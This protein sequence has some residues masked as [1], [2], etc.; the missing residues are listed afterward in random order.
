MAPP[1]EVSPYQL[2][3][4]LMAL[5]DDVTQL[6]ARTGSGRRFRP[7][8]GYPSEGLEAPSDPDQEWIRQEIAQ[9]RRRVE[10]LE[11]WLE[12][13][14]AGQGDPVKGEALTGRSTSGHKAAGDVKEGYAPDSRSASSA[15]GPGNAGVKSGPRRAEPLLS[16]EEKGAGDPG[17]ANAAATGAQPDSGEAPLRLP[18]E[19]TR[20]KALSA[21]RRL[22]RLGEPVTLASVARSAGLKYSQ[23]VYAFGRREG[24]L[25]E[26]RED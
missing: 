8:S 25:A 21:A 17:G 20:Q 10:A 14:G 22:R 16:A 12:A 13:P 2:G 4:K 11:R 5:L 9:L 7:A 3:F 26:L 19:V 18:R 1:C 23:V 24:L 6:L 15:Q